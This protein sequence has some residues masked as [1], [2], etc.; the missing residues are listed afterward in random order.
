MNLN[1][2][3]EFAG[4]AESNGRGKKSAQ[5]KHALRITVPPF[6]YFQLVK[7]MH[8]PCQLEPQNTTYVVSKKSGRAVA[9]PAPPPPLSLG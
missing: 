3:F 2:N 5:D 4:A 6:C 1:L 9:L 8:C 7:S